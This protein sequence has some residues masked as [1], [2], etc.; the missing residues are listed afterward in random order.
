[1]KLVDIYR[2]GKIKFVPE[3]G[4]KVV[5]A[6]RDVMP[7]QDE[8]TM[9][10]LSEGIERDQGDLLAP[11]IAN[12]AGEVLDGH[13]RLAIIRKRAKPGHHPFV[14]VV[15]VDVGAGLPPAERRREE[16]K[17]IYRVNAERRQMTAEQRREV[18]K[19]I[20]AMLKAEAQPGKGGPGRPKGPNGPLSKKEA[21]AEAAAG[22]G[23]SESAV[24]KIA[25]K[26][27]GPT[28]P[29]NRA[30]RAAL[31]ALKQYDAILVTRNSWTK[32]PK[33]ARHRL[34]EG[35]PNFIDILKSMLTMLKKE[36]E[37]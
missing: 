34:R 20:V 30:A 25:L 23:L 15:F 37:T 13:T 18:A 5:K 36:D 1:M 32:M 7:A 16:L 19:R 24:K 6:Y 27:K 21:Y 31:S 9:K 10:A 22:S 2:V 33:K 3:D 8:A 14:P 29:E 35:L 11:I 28:R 4:L 26:K 17:F 12:K